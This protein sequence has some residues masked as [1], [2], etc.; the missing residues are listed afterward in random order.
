VRVQVY[1][2]L[3]PVFVVSACA[4]VAQKEPEGPENLLLVFE[5]PRHEETAVGERWVVARQGDEA[6]LLH[7]WD[8]ERRRTKQSCGAVPRD[9]FLAGWEDLDAAGLLVSGEDLRLVPSPEGEPF[10][11]RLQLGFLNRGRRVSARRPLL[12]GNARVLLSVLRGWEAMLLPVPPTSLPVE[13]RVEVAIGGCGLPE[14]KGRKPA[15][16]RP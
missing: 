5:R 15:R 10:A 11:G 2:L 4:L 3:L 12:A 1:A 13:L 16:I 9:A 8:V 14:A 6:F 7:A